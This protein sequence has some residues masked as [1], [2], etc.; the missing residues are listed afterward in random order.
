M[1]FARIPFRILACLLRPPWGVMLPLTC[2]ILAII[3]QS[4]WGRLRDQALL[5]QLEKSK[6][7]QK[8]ILTRQFSQ[9]DD[10]GI[11]LLVRGLASKEE[12][13]ALASYQ[14]LM[15]QL[16]EWQSLPN[17][18]ASSRYLI[19]SKELAEISK[20]GTLYSRPLARDLAVMVQNDI[21]N[22]G[23]EGQHLVS[24]NCQKAIDVWQAGQGDPTAVAQFHQR[25]GLDTTLAGAGEP[26]NASTSI[27]VPY[28]VAQSPVAESHG[29]L[30]QLADQQGYE[31]G[32]SPGFDNF[33]GAKNPTAQS[34]KPVTS[35]RVGFYSLHSPAPAPQ[36]NDQILIA[37]SQQ[38]A[39]PFLTERLQQVAMRDLPKIP[40][41]DL[42]RLLNH[43]DRNISQQSEAILIKRDGF[44]EEHIQLARKLYHPD[45]SERKSLLPLL[46]GNDQLE[47]SNW[48]SELLHDPEQEVRWAT[49]K[50]IDNQVPLEDDELE[51]LKTIMQSD[52]DRRIAALGQ[53]LETRISRTPYSQRN[54]R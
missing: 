30:T 19:F 18:R 6:I 43:S 1:S 49:A 17:D 38:K 8:E 29:R 47:T 28:L 12:A 16:S 39:S 37:R 52:A 42:M 44:Q 27:N 11:R 33:S 13:T 54:R 7:N 26:R 23:F 31:S 48:L 36:R 45:I 4:P 35:P 14:T 2:M 32:E 15:Q 24:Q 41:Q 22:R 25:T 21:V 34:A 10:V 40:T 50:A 3:A 46:A 5:V 53:E 20:T 51:V 9:L